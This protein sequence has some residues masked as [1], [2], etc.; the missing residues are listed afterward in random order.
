MVTRKISVNPLPEKNNYYIEIGSDIYKNLACYLKKYNESKKIFLVSDENVFSIYGENIINLLES[1]N[2]NLTTYVIPPGE[3]SK[4][5]RYLQRGYD[6]L[7]TNNFSRDDLIIAF[8]GG[9]VGDLGGYLAATYMRGLPVMQIPTTLL[10][11]V[12]S[13]VGGKTAINHPVGKNLI[14]SFYQPIFVLID[15]DFLKTL[16]ERELKSGMAEVIKYALIKDKK[17]FEYLRKKRYNV[18]TLE[19]EVLLNII[20]KCCKIK[21]E[22]VNIDQKEKGKR[23]I[24]NFGHTI[25]HALEAAESFEGLKHGEAVA[26]GMIGAARLSHEFGYLDDGELTDIINIINDY[27]FKTIINFDRENIYQIMRHDK[28]AKD[29]KLRWVLLSNIGNTVIKDDIEE[30]LA[31]NVL[32]ELN[33]QQ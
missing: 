27:G 29:N 6:K 31:K 14:G 26:I 1:N 21:T 17:F 28:K 30:K 7:I 11:Q 16:P 20:E 24:L 12:D 23:M 10:A 8:G 15:I 13:S 32:G 19:K 25:G 9:V 4:S 22:I 3:K 2:Y 18:Y 33:C 5:S